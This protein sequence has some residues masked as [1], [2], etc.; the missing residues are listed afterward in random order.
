MPEAIEYRVSLA[1]RA[2][3]LYLVEARFPT[4]AAAEVDLRLPLWTPGSYLIREY[5]RHLQDLAVDD[6]AGR[7]LS[8][9]KVDKATW[10]VRTDGAGELRARYR[11]YAHEVT[12]R[13]AH[14][15]HTHAFW[16]GACLCLYVEALRDRPARVIVEAPAGWSIFTGL[17][18]DEDGAY[19]APDYDTL[20][21]SPFEVGPHER[22]DFSAL[23]RPHTIALWGRAPS[24]LD[25]DRL[26]ADVKKIVETQVAVF[27]S[28]L[29]Y[30]RY[31]FL[32]HLVSGGY[33]GLEHR[34]SSTIIASPH[35]FLTAN[36]Y[37]DL[38]ELIS[39]EYF[40]L[41]NVKRI[42]PEALGPSARERSDRGAPAAGS[43]VDGARGIDYQREAYTRSL[44]VV[45]GWTSYFD[46]L[47]IRRAGLQPPA[48]YLE[49]LAEEI[50]KL[51]AIPG[52]RRQSLEEA[53]FDAWIKLYRPDENT[54]NSTV[55]YYL[56]GSIVAL[57]LDLE[58]R[59]RTEGARCLDDAMRALWRTYGQQGRGY[60]D[61]AVQGIVEEATGLS[62]DDFFARAVRGHDE[63]DLDGPLASVGLGVRPRGEG[64]KAAW[65]GVSLAQDGDRLRV[66]EALDDG[67]AQAGGLYAGDQIVA[68]EGWR[69]D[70]DG[71][72]E[73]LSARKP[74]DTIRLAVFRRDELR[75]VEIALGEKPPIV[76]L[77][78][79]DEASP[80]AR[81]AYQAWLGAEWGK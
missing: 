23:G 56:K 14:L 80:A 44:W 59:R 67:P 7:A 60:P 35:A 55:S 31:T 32:L 24:V 22:L 5:Q 13:T 81:S 71:L 43:A 66:T 62:L 6:G 41:W 63:L 79:L 64:G 45:E 42:H 70:R 17:C 15:D 12:V 8:V 53:S 65:L 9:H 19:V 33:G 72:G 68:C 54:V 11:V 74:G 26:Q 29:P 78:F 2:R 3:H 57:L 36:K 51:L 48:R 73:R 50:G 75:E 47:A 61:A 1:E 39:H 25:R 10:R 49:K 69:V 28:Q 46:R 21:D 52:R 77:D 27:G 30:E 40:H 16:N 20:V 58:I 38:L 37:Q 34:N 76:E 4:E 18:A